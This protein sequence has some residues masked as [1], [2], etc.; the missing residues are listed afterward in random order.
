MP[1]DLQL[2]RL[3][4]P[5]PKKNQPQEVAVLMET[6]S[7]IGRS[8]DRRRHDGRRHDGRNLLAPVLWSRYEHRHSGLADTPD[9]NPIKG[10]HPS[11]PLNV[12]IIGSEEE[13]KEIMRAVG[14][15][16]A[17]PLGLKNNLRIATDN[18]FECSYNETMVSNLSLF[19]PKEDLA[20]E[21]P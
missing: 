3:R 17:D 7:E 8:R 15:H 16:A 1:A 6:A 10:G 4:Q 11:D 18:V 14:W 19:G 20:Y 12:E 2:P 21:Q 13:V 9:V 5:T